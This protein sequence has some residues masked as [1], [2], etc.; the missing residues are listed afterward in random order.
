MDGQ[1]ISNVFILIVTVIIFAIG[2]IQWAVMLQLKGIK[3]SLKSICDENKDD[4]RDIWDRLN[5]HRHST[6]GNVEIP[7]KQ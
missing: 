6:S 1:T 5:H 3:D 2:I 7:C 4:H